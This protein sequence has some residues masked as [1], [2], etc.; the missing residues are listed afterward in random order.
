M[1]RID[2]LDHVLL[3][4]NDG[5]QRLNAANP[6]GRLDLVARQLEQVVARLRQKQPALLRTAN[7]GNG[8]FFL[9]EPRANEVFMTDVGYLPDPL[10]AFYPLDPPPYLTVDYPQQA[11][12]LYA[13]VVHGR[14]HPGPRRPY[15]PANLPLPAEDLLRCIDTELSRVEQLR[16]L[17]RKSPAPREDA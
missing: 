1:D 11:H 3:L 2:V 5:R 6:F 15:F 4:V 10:G 16:Q 12:P 8:R 7:K 9:F 14:E 13:S 17:L